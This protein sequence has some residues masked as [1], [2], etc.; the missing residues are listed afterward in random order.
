ME[1]DARRVDSKRKKFANFRSRSATTSPMQEASEEDKV[2]PPLPGEKF[3]R[4]EVR[5]SGRKRSGQLSL[6]PQAVAPAL[7]LGA[8]PPPPPIPEGGFQPSA[9][10][11]GTAVL[12]ASSTSS[13]DTMLS[14]ETSPVGK[15]DGRQRLL[16]GASTP[17]SEPATIID[18]VEEGVEMYE[19]VGQ[20]NAP[21]ELGLDNEDEYLAPMDDS[22][23]RYSLLKGKKSITSEQSTPVEEDSATRTSQRRSARHIRKTPQQ[24]SSTSSAKRQAAAQ[25]WRERDAEIVSTLPRLPYMRQTPS[26]DRGSSGKEQRSQSVPSM[27]KGMDLGTSPIL[28]GAPPPES[29]SQSAL[30]RLEESEED[31]VSGSMVVLPGNNMESRLQLLDQSSSPEVQS[32]MTLTDDT[33]R[34][35]PARVLSALDDILRQ[36]VH[37]GVSGFDLQ[38]DI[39]QTD[40]ADSR[41]H[42]TALPAKRKLGHV[43]AAD[44]HVYTPTSTAAAAAAGK[45]N[46]H[47]AGQAGKARTASAPQLSIAPTLNLPKAVRVNETLFT[48][49]K[50]ELERY[51]PA[52]CTRRLQ[53]GGGPSHGYRDTEAYFRH[54]SSQLMGKHGSAGC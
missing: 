18:E 26:E 15:E 24:K 19:L 16:S 48:A 4:G 50:L 10:A 9:L 23:I 8:P 20:E 21:P 11:R 27:M 30:S 3:A 47:G 22:A 39:H 44:S 6:V 17:G 7:P 36:E 41:R 42:L 29:A 1:G 51:T 13:L 2:P 31:P 43:A 12:T 46:I 40:N 49:A 34:S 38:R 14:E 33:V 28:L 45:E 54:F 52:A 5:G 25:N 32:E 37:S 35:T 53:H